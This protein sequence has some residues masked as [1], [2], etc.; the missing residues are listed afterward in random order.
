MENRLVERGVPLDATIL[1]VPHHGRQGSSSKKF[2]N[3]VTPEVAVISCGAYGK[4]NYPSSQ[5]IAE[6]RSAG[7]LIFRTDIHGAITIE[8]DG[9]KYEVFCES[10]EE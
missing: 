4:G 7:A 3:S 10:S 9:E 2:V 5:V 1:K 8:T 6:Y